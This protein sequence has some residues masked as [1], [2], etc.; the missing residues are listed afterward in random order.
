[1]SDPFCDQTKRDKFH[2]NNIID[3]WNGDN[4]DQLI[5]TGEDETT[6]GK[7]PITNQY[8]STVYA[9][10]T[11]LANQVQA[12]FDVNKIAWARVGVTNEIYFFVTGTKQCAG[13]RTE[14]NKS[15]ITVEWEIVRATSE[16]IWETQP[17]DASPSLWFEGSQSFKVTSI[18]QCYL[19]VSNANAFD[20]EY[21]YELD[22][23]DQTIIIPANST[24]DNIH[25]RAR[26]NSYIVSIKLQLYGLKPKLL[27]QNYF[28]WPQ[29]QTFWVES[30][31]K[32][33]QE[34]TGAI[35]GK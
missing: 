18:G 3:W 14:R 2:I 29:I 32:L 23:I 4:V 27:V 8:D 24:I 10:L 12:E 31:P 34:K 25:Y 28:T 33:L 16:I 13:G 20:I 22:G 30:E 21:L 5:N 17:S 26:G 9:N 11:A 35:E 6:A 7:P 19:S 15:F 1:M